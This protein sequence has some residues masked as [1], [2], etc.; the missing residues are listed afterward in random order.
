MLIFLVDSL[1]DPEDGGRCIPSNRQLTVT[2][3]DNVISQKSEHPSSELS[4]SLPRTEQDTSRIQ[5]M[6]PYNSKQLA[7]FIK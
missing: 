1:L 2:A 4:V 6:K 7:S 3:L 5:V